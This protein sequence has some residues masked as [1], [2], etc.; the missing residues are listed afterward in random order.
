MI[1]G[2]VIVCLAVVLE[3]FQVTN[4]R[5]NYVV[6]KSGERISSTF[7]K[8]QRPERVPHGIVAITILTINKKLHC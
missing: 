8:V 2:G 4:P 7:N 1:Y 6:K 5:D 3:G